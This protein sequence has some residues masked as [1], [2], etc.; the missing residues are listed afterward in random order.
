MTSPTELLEN[1]RKRRLKIALA[2]SCTGGMIAAGL[3]DIPNA[4]DVFERGFVTYSN[5]AKVELLDVPPDTIREYGAVSEETALAMAEG[6]LRHSR[7]DITLAV[8]GIAG[9]GGASEGK[10]VGLIY[11]G[12]AGKDGILFA[13]RHQFT[14][15]RDEIRAKA[16]NTAY[17]LLQQELDSE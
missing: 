7:A 15:T 17:N 12:I 1:Y 13:E 4:S 5:D 10:P 8:T 6:C 3:T 11:F 9:P 2:E 14:G 16:R